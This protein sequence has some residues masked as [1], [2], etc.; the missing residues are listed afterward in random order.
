MVRS[1]ASKKYALHH[2]R[3]FAGIWAE[4]GSR[5]PVVDKTKAHRT[6]ED[7]VASNDLHNWLGNNFA[8][9]YAKKAAQEGMAPNS[10]T[11]ALDK[12]N[13][14]G[15]HLVRKVA[16]L[17][18]L[19]PNCK[20]A[21]LDGLWQK[22]APRPKQRPR[23]GEVLNHQWVWSSVAR[24]YTCAV[25]HKTSMC[26]HREPKLPG[27]KG[28]KIKGHKVHSS[29]DV[30]HICAETTCDGK[31]AEGFETI[32]FCN[33]CG[34]Y[35]Q[36]QCRNL[37][38]KCTGPI[39]TSPKSPPLYVLK[40]LQNGDHPVRKFWMGTPRRGFYD[41][42][43][44]SGPTATSSHAATTPEPA[45][46]MGQSAAPVDCVTNPSEVES[47]PWLAEDPEWDFDAACA[48]QDSSN[49]RELC[50]DELP[51]ELDELFGL[52]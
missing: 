40:R 18:T 48:E 50:L 19:W 9:E 30:Y 15:K 28:G 20:Q 41:H 21:I 3:P 1:A 43:K 38:K 45:R 2:A 25:C 46:V 22:P 26:T 39:P 27:C 34:K 16:F 36:Q 17:F 12:A 23:R 10:Y 49:L 52:T 6:K 5:F 8:D 51:E 4:M 44:Q 37:R 32:H 33:M 42:N 29:H 24:K 31:A 47:G 35:A 13:G 7:A 14:L 11:E